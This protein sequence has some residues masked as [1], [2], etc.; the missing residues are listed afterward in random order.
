M[1]LSLSLKDRGAL[2]GGGRR[3]TASIRFDVKEN[4][5]VTS[6]A[7]A[8]ALPR[9]AG[10]PLAAALRDAEAST[11]TPLDEAWTAAHAATSDAQPG[12]GDI[13]GFGT[14]FPHSMAAARPLSHAFRTSPF[15]DD[16]LL[17]LALSALDAEGAGE[18][19]T[20]LA[21]SLSA[22][23]FIGHTFGPDSWEA[24][25]ELARLDGA[26]A[27]FLRGLDA[28]FGP[29]GYA[30]VLTGDHG[31]TA[32]PEVGRHRYCDATPPDPWLRACQT[33]HRVLPRELGRALIARASDELGPGD[34]IAGVSDPY[35]D[36]SPAARALE[37]PRRAVLDAALREAILSYPG[38]AALYDL[39]SIPATCPPFTDESIDALVCRSVPP[40]GTPGLGDYY[41]VLSPGSFFNPT[42]VVGKGT[43][44]GSPY[45]YDRTVP[46]LARAPRR[47]AAGAVVPG[48]M[49][50]AFVDTAAALLG[51]DPPR[52]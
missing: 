25:D 42:V 45:F 19:P 29:D 1:I 33:A 20:L 41:V 7:V 2:F 31:T 5:F 46:L 51:I 38:V 9:W 13:P 43:S 44:H 36:L 22:N 50:T 10:A 52:R 47:I 34:W 4:R 6:T 14:V 23:D 40:A 28:R 8:R 39:R 21:V 37:P 48:A 49:F 35:V 3:P 27:R 24:W 26:L 11:W 15:S 18:H 16:V 12:E 32:M 17:G 30:V